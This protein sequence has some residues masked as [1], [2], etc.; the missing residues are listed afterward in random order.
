[1]PTIAR[2]K[3]VIALLIIPT[4]CASLALLNSSKQNVI[5][6]KLLTALPPWAEEL[7]RSIDGQV[8]GSIIDIKKSKNDAAMT[9]CVRVNKYIK[10][11]NISDRRKGTNLNIKVYNKIQAERIE[12]LASEGKIGKKM[13]YIIS[14]KI[15]RKDEIKL[16]E[17][18]TIDLYTKQRL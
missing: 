12:R 14:F 11:T 6:N 2:L 15:T 1:M 4:S 10:Q 8:V 7:N 13:E 18:I 3:I 16:H 9:L 17:L 5:H